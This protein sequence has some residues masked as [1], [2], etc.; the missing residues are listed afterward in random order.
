MN[1][2]YN[3]S[4]FE[5]SCNML[6]NVYPNCAITTDVIVGFP[7]E[8]EEEFNKTYEFLSKIKLY[9]MHIFK[10][11]PKKGTIAEKMPEQIDGNIKEIRSNKLI[12]LSDKNETEY[13]ESYIGKIVEVLFEEANYG[14]FKGHT[15]NY[16]EVKVKTEENLEDKILKVKI[17]ESDGL[18]LVG[19]LEGK[20]Q[21]QN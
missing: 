8:T 4:E 16:I 13:N 3:T 11:S 1:R 2:R 20:C 19:E 21:E 17:I 5:S 9:K 15:D 14:Y 7:G 10:Y 12:E 18:E 6:R